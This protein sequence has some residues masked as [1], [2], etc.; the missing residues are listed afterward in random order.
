MAE[1]VTIDQLAVEITQAIADYTDDVVQAIEVEV[2]TTAKAVQAD[3][4][5]DSPRRTGEYA[6][7]WA[8]KKEKQQGAISYTIYNK[9]K[10]TLTHLLEYGHAKRGGG[11]VEGKPHIEPAVDRHIP[12]MERRIEQIIERGG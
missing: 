2:E 10:P 8:R 7:G 9:N 12:A 6:K 11:R 3:I 4:K 5:A 1:T